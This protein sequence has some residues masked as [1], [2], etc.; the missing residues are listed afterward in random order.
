M[1]ASTTEETKPTSIQDTDGEM[2]KAPISNNI[3]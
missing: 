2:T 3:N 1:A